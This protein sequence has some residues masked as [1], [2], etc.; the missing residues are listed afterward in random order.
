MDVLKARKRAQKKG[1]EK[2]PRP[3]KKKRAKKSKASASPPAKKVETA[4]TGDRMVGGEAVE[5]PVSKLPE[6]PYGSQIPAET[7]IPEGAKSPEE[8]ELTEEDL[9]GLYGTQEMPE[10]PDVDI[11]LEEGSAVLGSEPEPAE[12]FGQEPPARKVTEGAR[13][14]E[15]I[16]AE[17][18]RAEPETQAAAEAEGI[19]AAD[20][21]EFY[22]IEKEFGEAPLEF[23]SFML[24]R[25]EYALPLARISEIIKPRTVTEVPRCPDFV[26]GIISLRGVIIPVFDLA[27]KLKF[28]NVGWERSARIVIVRRSDGE[29]VGLF[30]DSVRD[31]VRVLPDDI[32]PPPPALAG[33]EAQFLDGVGRAEDSRKARIEYTAD[34]DDAKRME[35]QQTAQR[36]LVILLNLDKV[37][38][39]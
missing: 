1:E 17:P 4:Q 16:K 28:G 6:D 29:L 31:V 32:E 24:G 39:L 37:A 35:L 12:T 18:V 38:V 11:T 30:V 10:L 19:K 15:E 21:D 2:K 34:I 25:E 36:K 7:D 13:Q 20:F 27:A 14:T 22:K 5:S 9:N 8:L 33:V 3:K 23:L 26:L